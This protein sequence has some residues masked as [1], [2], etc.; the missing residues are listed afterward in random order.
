MTEDRIGDADERDGRCQEC[1]CGSFETYRY[2]T[3]NRENQCRCTYYQC[4]SYRAPTEIP[5]TI[6][7]HGENCTSCTSTVRRRERVRRG[8]VP[9]PTEG[10]GASS[11]AELLAAGAIPTSAKLTGLE[12]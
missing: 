6:I 12:A 8:E 3:D 9:L 5:A 2:T 7:D 11:V 4:R 1:D 10:L